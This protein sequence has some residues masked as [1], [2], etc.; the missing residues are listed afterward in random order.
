MSGRRRVLEDGRVRE[1]EDEQREVDAALLQPLGAAAAR[2]P[3][4]HVEQHE[5][6]RDEDRLGTQ[7]RVRVDAREAVER[8]H[9]EDVELQDGGVLQHAV[10]HGRVAHRVRRAERAKHLVEREHDP[11]LGQ[12]A[13]KPVLEVHHTVVQPLL[14]AEELRE[15][16]REVLAPVEARRGLVAARRREQHETERADRHEERQQPLSRRLGA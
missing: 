14:D 4:E 16:C 1:E 15:A 7:A 8:H 2:H 3:V 11:D 5:H 9:R 13:V 12:R 10:E 6:A